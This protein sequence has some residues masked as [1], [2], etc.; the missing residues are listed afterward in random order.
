M[1]GEWLGG[2]WLVG[3]AQ[4]QGKE[5]LEREKNW[6]GNREN[7]FDLVTVYSEFAMAGPSGEWTTRKPTHEGE[8]VW[9]RIH[10][11]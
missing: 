3:W 2:W 8:Y 4:N 9:E 10:H 5:P 11:G 1:D 6:R 7:A